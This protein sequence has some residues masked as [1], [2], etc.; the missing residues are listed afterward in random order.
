MWLPA[1][2]AML[3]IIP[4][5]PPLSCRMWL[6]PISV[7]R[8]VL[9][10]TICSSGVTKYALIY[11][12]LG[13]LMKCDIHLNLYV[14]SCYFRWCSP[15]ESNYNHLVWISVCIFCEGV[16]IPLLF[17]ITPLLSKHSVLNKMHLNS[18]IPIDS[19]YIQTRKRS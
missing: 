13:L 1:R 11:L 16:L 5:L 6:N 17:L 3:K 9:T 7:P 10:W 2:E 18:R 4:P 19:N 12:K 15:F 14:W 8:I